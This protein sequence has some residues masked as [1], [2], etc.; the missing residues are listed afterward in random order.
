MNDTAEPSKLWSN[1]QAYSVFLVC[2]ILGSLTGYLIRAPRPA[3]AASSEAAPA[4]SPTGMGQMSPEQLKHMAD[5]KAE[6]LLA[7]LKSKPNDAAL[8]AKVGDLYVSVRQ[9]PEAQ[10]YY[11]RSIAVNSADP[12][13]LAHLSVCYSYAGEVDKAIATLQ[14]AL[15]ADPKFGIAWF[16][17]GMLEWN[18]KSNPKAAI[19]AWETLLKTNPNDP[20]RAQVEKL[21][22]QAKAHVNLAAGTVRER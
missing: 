14:Q 19:A 5:K 8:L 4:M 9:F 12:L 16:N 21:I 15:Q 1:A 3:N 20:H 22:A 18:A 6:P 10:G 13:V 2:L 7:A 17:L 11:E